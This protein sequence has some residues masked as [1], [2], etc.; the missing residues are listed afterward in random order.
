MLTIVLLAPLHTEIANA[1]S[2]AT[3]TGAAFARLMRDASR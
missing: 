2:I 1:E 3:A